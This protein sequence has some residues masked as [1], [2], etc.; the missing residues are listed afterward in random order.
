MNDELKNH[1]L[2]IQLEEA[3]R[4]VNLEVIGPMLPKISVE[5]VL[6]LTVMTA[7]MRGRYLREAFALRDAK[8]EDGLVSSEEIAKL[9]EYRLAYEEAQAVIRALEHA[10]ERG[11]VPI[12]GDPDNTDKD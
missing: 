1:R 9:K 11:Y 4:A 6:P 2:K 10:I 12:N 3:I 7:K 5:S 8:G